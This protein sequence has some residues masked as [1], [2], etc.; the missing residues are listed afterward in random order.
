M[1]AGRCLVVDWSLNG[2]RDDED[3][4]SKG[5]VG[6]VVGIVPH[7]RET[8]LRRTGSRLSELAVGSLPEELDEVLHLSSLVRRRLRILA[9]R[10]S[11]DCLG[12]RMAEGTLARLPS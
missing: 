1:T 5:V 7:L 9:R 6:G 12:W 4:N 10:S 11:S 2:K 8:R 3:P